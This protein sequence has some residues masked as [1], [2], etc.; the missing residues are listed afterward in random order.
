MPS[1]RSRD[2]V[3]EG[4][5]NDPSEVNTAPLN[6]W[7]SAGT[8]SPRLLQLWCAGQGD[9]PSSHGITTKRTTSLK[10]ESLSPW[11]PSSVNCSHDDRGWEHHGLLWSGEFKISSF[12][13][14]FKNKNK[15]IYFGGK[16]PKLKSQFSHHL[17]AYNIE[18][19]IFTLSGKEKELFWTIWSK[20]LSI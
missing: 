2:G 11:S 1:P 6:V 5:V 7:I 12:K 3:S 13:F 17:I 19:K 4:L 9:P 8:I 10:R 15:K 16:C 14:S 20:I 18:A